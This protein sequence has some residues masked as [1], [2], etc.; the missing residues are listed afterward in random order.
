[1]NRSARRAVLAVSVVTIG[2]SAHADDTAPIVERWLTCEECVNGE[3]AR[4]R[5]LGAA[6]IPALT[7][8]VVGPSPSV[9]ANITASSAAS[10]ARARR[11]WLTLAASER[12]LRPL[13][14]S[15]AYVARNVENFR[16]VYQ[17]RAALGLRAIDPMGAG[18]ILRAKLIANDSARVHFFRADVRILLDSLSRAP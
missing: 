18:A 3:L 6:A 13:H 7:E 1:M 4:L 10:F 5:V 17:I 2:C 12:L 15:A 16:S 14:D 11:Y 9:N 8:A